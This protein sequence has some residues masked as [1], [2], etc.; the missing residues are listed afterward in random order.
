VGGGNYL[1]DVLAIAGGSNVLEG[2]DNAYSEIDRE[3]LLTL[4][5]DVVI[6]LL[7][8]AP[9]QVVRQ[10]DEFW[11][12]V[13]QVPAVRNRRVHILTDPYV[14]LGGISLGRVAEQFAEILHPR[15]A[16]TRP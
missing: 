10:A 7:P 16:T 14:L 11:Q 8:S 4:N 2:G 12:S 15:S 5:P 3:R 1:D 13:P 9:P 6:V